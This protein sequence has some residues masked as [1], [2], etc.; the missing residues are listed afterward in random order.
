MRSRKYITNGQGSRSVFFLEKNTI[1]RFMNYDEVRKRVEG[2]ALTE[3]SFSASAKE[4]KS[5][6][7]EADKQQNEVNI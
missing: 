2:I 6:F 7:D 4:L 5:Q 3:A 1:S